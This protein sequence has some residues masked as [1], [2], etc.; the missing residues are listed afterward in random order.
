MAAGKVILVG[1]GP[2]D[3]GLLTIRGRECLGESDVV[4]YDYLANP[5][6]LVH[7]PQAEK[8]CLGKHGGG[9][10]YSQDEI[11]ELIIRHATSGKTVV[12][13]KGGDPAIFARA[14]EELEAIEGRGI[15]FEVV[16]GITAA[17]AVTGTV[18]IPLTHREYSSAVALVTG[19]GK[20]GEPPESINYRA[21]ADF[22]G[23][24]V[25]YMGTT[26]AEYWSGELI[27]AGKD[28]ATP[29]V[30]VR[31][32]SLPN[33]VSFQ[34]RLDEVADR[35]QSGQ[36]LRPPVLFVVGETAGQYG[37]FNWFENRPL[38]GKRVLVTRPAHQSDSVVEA[39][40]RKGAK[41]VCQPAIEI[42]PA[43]DRQPI[44]DCIDRIGEFDWVVFSSTNGVEFF[45]RELL[46]QGDLRDLARCRLAAIGP[47][48]AD[49]LKGFYLNPD[50]VPATFD[51]DSLAASLMPAVAGKRVLLVRASRGREILHDELSRS[52]AGV[53]QV[54]FYESVDIERADPR[55]SADMEQGLFDYVMASS[56]A[57]A[58]SLV[59]MFGESLN[60][61]RLVSIS[62]ITSDALR[63]AGFEPQIESVVSTIPGMVDAICADA[64]QP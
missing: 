62:P 11:N 29:V 14:H 35:I 16:P 55:I 43:D 64:V 18:G 51:A 46:E 27:R 22:P 53:E 21:L 33:Q 54:V 3:P 50:V 1:A 45:M 5:R 58:R 2:G 4:L 47:A 13:L 48:T 49:C 61:T 15:D 26:T 17:L 59:A 31:H 28:P 24:L 19:Q 8:I 42:R 30:A 63:A 36:R 57:I 56:S 7:A 25:F 32:C 38:F 20:Q 52:A 6:L 34:C 10:I 23:T 60:R 39:L 41:V 9:R 44:L 40:E 37:R 12:R